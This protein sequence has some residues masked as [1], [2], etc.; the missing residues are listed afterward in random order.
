[1]IEVDYKQ[2]ISLNISLHQIY[3]KKIVFQLIIIISEVSIE[4]L[5]FS[6]AIDKENIWHPCRIVTVCL[7]KL[8]ESI[9][10]K[11]INNELPSFQKSFGGWVLFEKCIR[12]KCI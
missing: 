11:H 5:L 3:L 4:Y 12:R 9:L 2:E 8:N 6:I 1:M 10:L 7:I